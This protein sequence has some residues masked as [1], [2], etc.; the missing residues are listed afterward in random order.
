[1]N[2]QPKRKTIR[3]TYRLSS[4]ILFSCFAVI[5][6][7]AGGVVAQ[8]RE[9]VDSSGTF[10]VV[11]DLVTVDERMIV[12]KK[13]NGVNINVPLAKLSVKDLTYLRSLSTASPKANS[14]NNSP[15]ATAHPNVAQRNTVEISPAIES[16]SPSRRP[17]I[18]ST[19]PQPP[20][21]GQATNLPST[22]P[23]ASGK[24]SFEL[25]FD[26]SKTEGASSADLLEGSQN[27]VGS[28]GMIGNGMTGDNN[29][30]NRFAVVKQP[31]GIQQA[32]P[33]MKI[34]EPTGQ[35]GQ[36][37]R[38]VSISNRQAN[39]GSQENL[40][41]DFD[42]SSASNA[43]GSKQNPV[44]LE[45][46]ASEPLTQPVSLRSIEDVVAV[47]RQLVEYNQQ[48]PNRTQ[49]D[50][51]RVGQLTL[52]DD[53]FVRKLALQLVAKYDSVAGFDLILERLNDKSF[54]VR[55]L[56]YDTL[57]EL[58]D[59][60]A[61]VPLVSRF[62]GEDRSKISSVLSSF[63]SKAESQMIPFLQDDSRDVRMSACSFLSKVGTSYSIPHLE[64]LQESDSELLVRM[65]ARNAVRKI[66]SRR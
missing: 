63:G 21:R 12:L 38:N 47:R 31:S 65:Q 19:D 22:S 5:S 2:C 9:W 1:M 18:G 3:S 61:I 45:L 62:R 24:R 59:E 34:T 56:A 14:K 25:N 51:Q 60:R 16:A 52:S 17:V 49:A 11:A 13:R 10:K 54:E 50:L 37:V 35:F 55:W 6:L 53:K 23:I 7:P 27:S 28:S 33:A 39:F 30:E 41:T 8:E 43:V 58:A 20:R 32:P 15:A 42:T 64:P 29:A 66:T 48:W 36:P 44:S 57:E 4:L 26:E 46:A 40:R